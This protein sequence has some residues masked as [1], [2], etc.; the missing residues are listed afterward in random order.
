MQ[1]VP[2]IRVNMMLDRNLR[3]GILNTYAFEMSTCYIKA[4]TEDMS[5]EVP[6]DCQFMRLISVWFAIYFAQFIGIEN[7]GIKMYFQS[8]ITH[9]YSQVLIVFAWCLKTM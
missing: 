6:K 5:N 9:P 8:I 3:S 4:P 1:Y 7:F 2:S